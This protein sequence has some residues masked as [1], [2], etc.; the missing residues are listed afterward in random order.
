MGTLDSRI[1]GLH[2]TLTFLISIIEAAELKRVATCT[3][4]RGF[5]SAVAL[6]RARGK[7]QF[8][9]STEFDLLLLKEEILYLLPSLGKD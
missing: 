5:G 6:Q 9:L 8:P 2:Q 7:N 1:A 3:S 4:R